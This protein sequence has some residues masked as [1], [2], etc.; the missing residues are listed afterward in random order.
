MLTYASNQ[1]NKAFNLSAREKYTLWTVN[2]VSM[3]RLLGKNPR[4][5][6]RFYGSISSGKNHQ[7]SIYS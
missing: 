7:N 4:G 1:A 3:K 5:L 2:E 6:Y